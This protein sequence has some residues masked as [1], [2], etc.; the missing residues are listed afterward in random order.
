MITDLEHMREDDRE[1]PEKVR[2]DIFCSEEEKGS[3]D[4]CSRQ[5]AIYIDIEIIGEIDHSDDPYHR[6]RE[7]MRKR[8]DFSHHEM[9]RRELQTDLMCDQIHCIRDDRRDEKMI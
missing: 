4:P 1:R 8:K 6:N 7:K 5:E 2:E 9:A 3:S